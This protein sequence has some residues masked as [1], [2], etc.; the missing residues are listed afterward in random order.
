MDNLFRTRVLTASVNEIRTPE[1]KIYDRFFRSKE[2][3]QMTSRLAF[4]IITGNE[5]ILKNL[6]IYAPASM[7]DKTSRRTI[8]LEA[9]RLAE[10]RLINAAELEAMRAFGQQFATELIKDRI[11]REQYDMKSKF[12]RTLEFWACNALKGKIYDS[13]LASI[14]VDYGIAGTHLIT[15]ATGWDDP[16]GDPIGDIRT[17]KRLIEL[18]ALTNITSWVAY[19]GYEVMN[20]L[21]SNEQVLNL[22]K[23]QYGLQIATTGY[24]SNLA[25]VQFEEYNAGY[26]DGAGTRQYF[27]GA[28]Q[29]MLIGEC[30]DLTDCPFAPIMN[31]DVSGGIGNVGSGGKGVMIYSDSKTEWDPSGRWIRT[32][33]RPLPVLKRPGAVIIADVI[34]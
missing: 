34:T 13:D 12:D 15:L 19:C 8:T 5:T 23:Q 27:V 2:N 18:D 28:S 30:S 21:L 32:E 11:A 16:A 17:W 26:V 7:G 25:G 9:P 20:A 6:S 4:D 10:K 1:T 3:M 31:M 14:L 22:M 33:C 29:I 24:I